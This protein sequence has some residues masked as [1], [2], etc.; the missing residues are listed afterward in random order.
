MVNKA[1]SD[2]SDIN[3]HFLLLLWVRLARVHADVVAP[4]LFVHCSLR[5]EVKSPLSLFSLPGSLCFVRNS[6]RAEIGDEVEL[7]GEVR[8]EENV[9]VAIGLPREA[10]YEARAFCTRRCRA[11]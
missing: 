7:L 11:S 5:F 8:V 2:T 1:T 3:Q 10:V 4:C 9:E 6:H